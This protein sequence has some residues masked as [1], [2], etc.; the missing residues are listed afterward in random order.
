MN[1]R[2]AYVLNINSGAVC[3]QTSA[4]AQNPIIFRRI[5]EET[6][7]MIV[8]GQVKAEAVVEAIDRRERS[9]PDFSWREY[10]A[11]RRAAEKALN[12][13]RRE[14]V[15]VSDDPNEAGETPAAEAQEV[16][17]AKD[18]GLVAGKAA[19]PPKERAARAEA[20]GEERPAKAEPRPEAAKVNL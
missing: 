2:I 13:S 12:V 3:V 10:D 14:M 20:K 6:A 18:L 5:D 9:A 17:S 15:P 19:K 4:T 11:R 16:V 7:Q 1:G 8:R